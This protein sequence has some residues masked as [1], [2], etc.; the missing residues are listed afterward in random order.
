M[1]RDGNFSNSLLS[2]EAQLKTLLEEV[3]GQSAIEFLDTVAELH[4][5]EQKTALKLLTRVVRKFADSNTRF[6]SEGDLALKRFEEDLYNDLVRE[7]E[8]RQKNATLR[9]VK[10]LEEIETD[11]TPID[12]QAAKR[13]RLPSA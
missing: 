13:S 7:F 3:G 6:P 9:L 1:T 4:P 11:S 12:F 10:D 2:L 8:T 5:S